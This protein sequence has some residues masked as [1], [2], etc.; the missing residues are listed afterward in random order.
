MAAHISTVVANTRMFGILLVVKY[1]HLVSAIIA[2]FLLTFLLFG[3]VS[4]D[5]T[6]SLVYLMKMLFN[7]D[8]LSNSTHPSI[9]DITMKSNYLAMCVTLDSATECVSAHNLTS[10]YESSSVVLTDGTYSL[11]DI[12]SNLSDVCNPRLL[13]SCIVLS[14]ILVLFS[15]W[16][17]IPLIPW[18][19]AARRIAFG[20]GVILVLLWGLGAMLQHQT[21][22]TAIAVLEVSSLGL[23]SMKRGGRAEAMTWTAFLFLAVATIGLAFGCWRDMRAIKVTV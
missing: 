7:A 10:L 23:I 21:V 6:Y 3:C 17:A 2:A 16:L 13:V 14:L 15:T 11:S 12:A 22:L 19:V 20:F 4:T 9:P 1:V 18:K 8:A 5:L